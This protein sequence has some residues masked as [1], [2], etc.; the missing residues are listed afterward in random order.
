M[1]SV[2]DVLKLLEQ[3]PVWKQLRQLPTQMKDLEAR[4]ADLERKAVAPAPGKDRICPKCDGELKVTG[5][6]PHRQFK[7]A[8]VET[9]FVACQVCDYKAERLYDPNKT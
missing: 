9:H 8:G 2:S 1:I 3:V 4:V 6:M 7:F 5:T